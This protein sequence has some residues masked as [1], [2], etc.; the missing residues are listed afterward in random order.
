LAPTASPSV[1]PTLNPTETPTT[2]PTAAAFPPTIIDF[3]FE[4]HYPGIST[5]SVEDMTDSNGACPRGWTCTGVAQVKNEEYIADQKANYAGQQGQQYFIIGGDKTVGSATS[6]EFTL[7]STAS[8]VQYSRMGGATLPSGFY[9]MES[10]DEPNY[11]CQ[12]NDD[13]KPCQVCGP[14]DTAEEDTDIFFEQECDVSKA[15]GLK[16]YLFVQDKDTSE[17]MGKVMI[18]DIHFL[19]VNGYILGDYRMFWKRAE[20]ENK[21]EWQLPHKIATDM[22]CEVV[23]SFD[24]ET[25]SNFH[26][27]IDGEVRTVDLLQG[28]VSAN[29]FRKD[30]FVTLTVERTSG[31]VDFLVEGEDLGIDGSEMDGLISTVGFTPGGN[32]QVDQMNCQTFV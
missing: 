26:M 9:V 15:A 10:S 20:S 28:G 8:K 29:D 11:Q 6:A 16:V 30:R 5:S 2:S 19:D 14:R 23:V 22:K 31:L 1:S 27:T 17:Q 24:N 32:L 3:N 4:G 21:F 12:N 7:P 13:G 18:D 25:I